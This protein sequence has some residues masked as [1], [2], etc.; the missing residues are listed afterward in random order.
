MSQQQ[1]DIFFPTLLSHAHLPLPPVWEK[2]GIPCPWRHT[3]WICAAP[4]DWLL[5]S[6]E[7]SKLRKTQLQT[8]QRPLWGC[9]IIMECFVPL[10]DAYLTY[11]MKD[12]CS[13]K[14]NF[15]LSFVNPVRL[16]GT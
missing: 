7:N 9:F 8:P 1:R 3:T 10:S 16:R 4:S 15:I 13:L 11:G 14:L 2:R 6:R 5:L 12:I